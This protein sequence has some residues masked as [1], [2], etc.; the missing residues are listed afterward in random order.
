[1]SETKATIKAHS[2]ESVLVSACLLG[3]RV[4]YDGGHSAS[5]SAILARWQT[6]GRVCTF[7]PEVAGGLSTPRPPAELVGGTG[8]DVLDG[9]A[10]VVTE[11]G[12]DVT[13]A[14]L[15]GA[16]DALRAALEVNA[17]LAVLKS[18][19]PS[20]GAHEIYDG[21][22]SGTRRAGQGVTAALLTRHDI[23]VFTEHELAAA[24][25]YLHEQ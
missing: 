6:E 21:T 9:T 15:R 1:M 13:Q 8:A 11:Q 24:D 3:R 19:S 14:F 23:R 18:K 4:R 5:D 20:C 7:C 10:K 16:H 2:A 25:A 22:F 12:V 17:K